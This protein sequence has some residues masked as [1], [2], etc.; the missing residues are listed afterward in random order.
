MFCVS[1]HEAH[2]I[3]APRPKVEP[4]FPGGPVEGNHWATREVPSKKQALN[5]EK[6]VQKLHRLGRDSPGHLAPAGRTQP[7]QGTGCLLHRAEAKT[8]CHRWDRQP[9]CQLPSSS[10]P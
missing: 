6:K 10:G 4:T 2:E 3:L 7:C 1:G 9:G 8:Y 5:P